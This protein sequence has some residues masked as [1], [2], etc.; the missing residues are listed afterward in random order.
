[1]LI[2]KASKLAFFLVLGV[3]LGYFVMVKLPQLDVVNTASLTTASDT[4]SNSRLSYLG[5]VKNGSAPSSG[6]SSVQIDTTLTNQADVDTNHLFPKDV[7]CFAD[8]SYSGCSTQ[9]TYTVNS[10]INTSTFTLTSPLSSTL[11]DPDLAVATQSATHTI[12]FTTTSAVPTT[13]DILITIPAIQTSGKTNDGFP[14]TAATIANNGFDLGGSKAVTTSD[15]SIGSSG[16]ANNWTVAAVTAATGSNGHTIRIDRNTNS[17]AGGSTL[18]ITIGGSTNK[19]INPAPLNTSHTQ[20]TAD[21]YTVSAVTRDGGDVTLDSINMKVAPVEAVLVSASVDQSLSFSIT[22]Q[23]SGSSRC[24]ATTDVTTTATSVPWGTLSSSNTFYNAAHLLTVSTNAPGG[25]SVTAEENDQMGKDGVTCSGASAGE[26]NNCIKDTTCDGGTCD[27]G[28]SAEWTTSS[29]NGFGYS[30]ANLSGSDAAFT[31][32]ES[33]RTFSSKQFA[34]Q[35][36]PEAKATVMTNAGTVSAKTAYVCYRISLSG[37]QPAGY[38]Y[39][40]VKYTATGVF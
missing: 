5:G 1:M 26:A 3:S 2:K 24:G 12:V 27:Q 6:D 32:N 37:T 30:L 20:G 19:L 34:D 35:E 28:T 14:D 25:Y 9:S 29:I 11:H 15:V 36:V 21:V 39:N 22:G 31:Y 17:C 38:Y 8:A 4:L 40:K 16:C 33:S 10:I 18:T 7:L 13:G 23:T